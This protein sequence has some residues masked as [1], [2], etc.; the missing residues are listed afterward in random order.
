MNATLVHKHA[1][2]TLND[3]SQDQREFRFVATRYE[4][5]RDGE[6]I[7]PKGLDVKD[8][9]KNPVLLLLHDPNKPIGRV[10]SLTRS[11]VDG[12][13]AWV[14]I[15][16][17]DPPG[18]SSDADQAHRQRKAGSLNGISIAFQA[19]E[20]NPRPVLPGQTGPTY[21]K[22]LLLEVS[23]VTI[24]SC[25]N[26][27]VLEK[28]LQ[29]ETAMNCA[30]QKQNIDWS[31]INRELDD[32]VEVDVSQDDVNRVIDAVVPS[33]VAA[34]LGVVATQAATAAM[35]RLTGRLD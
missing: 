2:T 32:R 33:L 14:G 26:C 30:C 24:P 34:A 3:S 18:T 22:T 31:A 21:T 17:I 20:W 11:I 15:A 12:E 8:F 29:K 9:I 13:W 19:L 27:L 23:L 5:D 6:V 7:D 4:V 10:M 1:H 28:T 16:R 35:N 25:A